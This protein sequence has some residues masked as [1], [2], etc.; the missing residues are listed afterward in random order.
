M[1]LVNNAVC[2]NKL[3]L[4]HEWEWQISNFE[5]PLNFRKPLKND[6]S[7]TLNRIP[8]MATCS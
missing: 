4:W 1:N 3:V 2:H 7:Q 6:F 5:K 8:N